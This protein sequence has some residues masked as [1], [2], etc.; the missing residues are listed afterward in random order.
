MKE[1]AAQMTKPDRL[2]PRVFPVLMVGFRVSGVFWLGGRALAIFL[3]SFHKLHVSR[4]FPKPHRCPSYT[5]VSGFEG[6]SGLQICIFKPDLDG[7]LLAA[8]EFT[9]SPKP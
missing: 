9:V 2:R 4:E 7:Y 3:V 8:R 5:H 1:G 6:L